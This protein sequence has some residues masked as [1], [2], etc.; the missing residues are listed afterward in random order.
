MN[1]EIVFVTVKIDVGDFH[2]IS[3][4]LPFRDL[5]VNTHMWGEITSNHE[6]FNA[7]LTTINDLA[8]EQYGMKRKS[9]EKLQ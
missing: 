8:L 9:E 1:D 5:L 7:L 3:V 4:R 6:G 2:L